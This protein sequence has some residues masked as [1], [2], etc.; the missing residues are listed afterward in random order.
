MVNKS[1]AIL[2]LIVSD[3]ESPSINAY[4]HKLYD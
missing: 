2:K 4:S 1:P 3:D